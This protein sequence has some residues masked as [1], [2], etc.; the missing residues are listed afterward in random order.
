MAA[1]DKPNKLAFLS[2]PAPASYVAGLGRGSVQ[3]GPS[4]VAACSCCIQQRFWFHDPVGYRS[5]SRRSFGRSH[6]VSDAVLSVLPS[7]SLDNTEKRKR[8]VE[9]R[10]KSTRTSSRTLTTNT[11]SSQGQHMRPT[12]RRR[13]G[14]MSRWTRTW[15]PGGARGGASL[16]YLPYVS[17]C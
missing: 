7:H 11:D 14:Y 9:R 12:M 16:L 15:T 4:R 5:C 1:K 17:V 8:S 2:M 6:R 10:R 13:T 3:L